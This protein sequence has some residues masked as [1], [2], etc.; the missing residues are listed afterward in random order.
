MSDDSLPSFD[1]GGMYSDRSKAPFNQV[2]KLK[3]QKDEIKA[4]D[5][6]KIAEYRKQLKN[7]TYDARL[8]NLQRSLVSANKLDNNIRKELKDDEES[9]N[10]E[11]DE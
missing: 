6:N 3:I 1:F 5:P 11:E 9:I 7:Y 8:K 2:Q 10:S 4:N